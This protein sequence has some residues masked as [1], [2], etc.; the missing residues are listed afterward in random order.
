MVKRNCSAVQLTTGHSGVLLSALGLAISSWFVT[1]MGVRA[2]ESPGEFSVVITELSEF[3]GGIDALIVLTVGLYLGWLALFLLDESK[4]L[5]AGLLVIATVGMVYTLAPQWSWINWGNLFYWVVLG[6]VFA[7]LPGYLWHRR[8]GGPREFPRATGGGLAVLVLATV[9]VFLEIYVPYPGGNSLSLGADFLTDL[10][11]TIVFIGTL[12]YFLTYSHRQD[13]FVVSSC[14][15]IETAFMSELF[16]YT[17]QTRQAKQWG[18][19]AS[20]LNTAFTDLRLGRE[21]DPIRGGLNLRFRTDNALSMWVSVI[22]D[23]SQ[24]KRVTDG[25]IQRLKRRSGT[26]PVFATAVR[27]LRFW[28]SEPRD[29][30]SHIYES[31]IVLLLFDTHQALQTQTD[32]ADE[33]FE[34]IQKMKTIHNHIS[35]RKRVV[36]VAMNASTG[37]DT[38]EQRQA[39][40]TMVSSISTRGYR[41][42]LRQQIFGSGN[43]ITVIPVDRESDEQYATGIQ[44][45]VETIES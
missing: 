10:S 43:D 25:D 9:I 38:F 22:T 4:Q 32:G 12:V 14:P 20:Q 6:F 42:F 35:S 24:V 37:V 36:A 15:Q 27:S 40:G 45:V 11:F 39:T 33:A 23:S 2:W 28:R 26:H 21:V 17:R 19:N 5:Q 29:I 41:V 8:F 3:L 7:F 16:E 30:T 13:V 31:D 18:G 44:E 1:D 34:Q